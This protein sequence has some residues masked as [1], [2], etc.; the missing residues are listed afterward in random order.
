MHWL[1]VGKGCVIVG[2]LI[3]EVCEVTYGATSVSIFHKLQLLLGFFGGVA[4]KT[5]MFVFDLYNYIKGN[6]WVNFYLIYT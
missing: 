5:T 6:T 4:G 3:R 1:E 2:M